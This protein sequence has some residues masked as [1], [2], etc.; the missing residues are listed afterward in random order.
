MAD[1]EA[2]AVWDREPRDVVAVFDGHGRLL[3]G[4]QVEEDDD[5]G[6]GDEFDHEL[7]EDGGDGGAVFVEE[8]AEAFDGGDGAAAI[9][10]CQLDRAVVLG[11]HKVGGWEAVGGLGSPLLLLA[12]APEDEERGLNAGDGE[13]EPGAD[14]DLD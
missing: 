12:E 6:R 11:F 5:L 10:R 4:A 8:D 7:A 1:D 2:I 3:Q 14:R 9:L 13:R